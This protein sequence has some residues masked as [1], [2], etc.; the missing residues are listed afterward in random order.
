MSMTKAGAS[1]HH[2]AGS[3]RL[4]EPRPGAAALSTADMSQI[5]DRLAR[6][7]TKLDD[8]HS[9]RTDHEQRIRA[10]E[11]F[12]WKVAGV[13][14]VVAAASSLIVQRLVGA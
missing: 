3:A 1:I 9:G 8:H 2:L 10:L 4:D 12:R 6:I 13:A 7:E 11:A 5:L 14:T